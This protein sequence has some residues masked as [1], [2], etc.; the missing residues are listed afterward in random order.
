MSSGLLKQASTNFEKDS[1]DSE[2]FP[3][4]DEMQFKFY[5]DL[6]DFNRFIVERDKSDISNIPVICTGSTD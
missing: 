1:A 5:R 4:E 3:F 2:F 6:P